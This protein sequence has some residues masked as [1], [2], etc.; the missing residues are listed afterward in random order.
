M[1][2]V[3]LKSCLYSAEAAAPRDISSRLQGLSLVESP[4]DVP[5]L[6]SF[7][8]SAVE[9]SD[10][11]GEDDDL[12]HAQQLLREY[13][14]RE[15]VTVGELD[16]GGEERYEKTTAKHGDATFSR[17]MKK[18][19]LCPRQILR[20]CRGGK[21]L[22]I[23]EPLSNLAQVVSVCGSCGRSRIFELQLMPALVSLL[24]KAD[25]NTALEFGTVLVYTCTNSC[26]EAELR[27]TVEE[28]CIVQTD[29]DQ[30][31]FK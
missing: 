1:V 16:G 26:W 22:F 13:E 4:L 11:F 3:P 9:E 14:R 23:S 18:I 10:L 8:I 31:L 15:G 25:S 21:P 12:E 24:Q 5:V 6:P 19:S 30:Q 20:Y 17:F 29:P 28:L 27:S 2:T 7:F